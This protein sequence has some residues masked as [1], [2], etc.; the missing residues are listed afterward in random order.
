[1]RATSSVRAAWSRCGC[2]R[3]ARV[4][5]CAVP[6]CVSEAL[7]VGPM[8]ACVCVP[9]CVCVCMCLYVWVCVMLMCMH[10]SVCVLCWSVCMC[11]GTLSAAL[12]RCCVK[13]EQHVYSMAWTPSAAVL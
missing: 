11:V 1:M 9:V 3:F 12:L 8:R 7:Q 5:A 2:A 10:L 4:S 6:V 13:E